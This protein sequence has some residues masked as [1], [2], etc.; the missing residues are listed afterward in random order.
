MPLGHML[1]RPFKLIFLTPIY[2][3]FIILN[4]YYILYEPKQSKIIL[5]FIIQF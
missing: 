5:I 4:K 2:Q 1:A 3:N